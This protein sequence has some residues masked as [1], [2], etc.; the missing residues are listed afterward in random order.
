MPCKRRRG[1]GMK[2]ILIIEDDAITAHLYKNRLEQEG[3]KVEVA[4]DGQAGF[5]RIH[6]LRPSVVLLDL[7]L[8]KMNGI[9]ILKKTRGYSEFADLPVLVFTN[10]YLPNLV[11]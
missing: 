3:Y 9:D 6:D 1:Q 8:P 7:M 10:A 4:A 2:K 11:K 5:Y